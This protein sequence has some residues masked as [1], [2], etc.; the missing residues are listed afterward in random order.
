MR[1]TTAL[2]RAEAITKDEIRS[3]MRDMKSGK[4]P[5]TDEKKTSCM[6]YLTVWEDERVPDD[7]CRGLIVKLPKKGG[8]N[9]LRKQERYHHHV[10]CS[11]GDG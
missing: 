8:S 4:A 10:Y 5:R 1:R 7:C 11:Q 6:C 3:S 9:E 2:T